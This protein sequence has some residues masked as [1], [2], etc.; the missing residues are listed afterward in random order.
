MKR[1]W[2]LAAA[3]SACVSGAAAQP[4]TPPPTEPASQPP[5]QT[6]APA[7]ASAPLAVSALH[8]AANTPVRIEL[9][10][11]VSSKGRV[12]GD[13]FA[14]KLAAPIV[15][16]GQTIAPAGATGV[17][18]VVY[19]EAG[20]GGGAPG[21]L[22][23][24]ARYIDVGAVRI[25]LKAFN[26]ASGGESN[27]REMQV[28]AEFLSVGVMFIDGHDVVYPIGTRAGAKVAEDVDLP[29]LPAAAPELATQA[30]PSPAPVSPPTVDG[31]TA[32]TTPANTVTKE[33]SK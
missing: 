22:V 30:P 28:A 16:D 6:V 24:A 8:L 4:V 9:A 31:A 15:V 2:L 12:R 20:S 3:M 21:K 25:H 5:V 26:L 17:G 1:E 10:D 13:K 14:I 33:P 27:F 7:P 29:V 11:A 18:E 19:A 32:P 23:L